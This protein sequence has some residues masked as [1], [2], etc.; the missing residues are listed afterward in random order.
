MDVCVLI[1]YFNK[2]NN[3]NDNN[4]TSPFDYAAPISVESKFQVDRLKQTSFYIMV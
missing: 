1:V 2:Q 4:I 3:I